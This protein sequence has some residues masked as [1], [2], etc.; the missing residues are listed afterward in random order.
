MP[1]KFPEKSRGKNAVSYENPVPK[2]IIKKAVGNTI[3]NSV[4]SINSTIGK[5]VYSDEGNYI[6][7]IVDFI[8]GAN[9]IDSIKID[10][11][12]E[13]YKSGKIKGCIINFK[14]IKSFG[15]V[16]IIDKAIV[17]DLIEKLKINL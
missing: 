9:R 10:I 7:S 14:N 16:I 11:K 8:I 5:E 12:N 17:S 13:K 2:P 15:E 3:N 4:A 1:E 6:G